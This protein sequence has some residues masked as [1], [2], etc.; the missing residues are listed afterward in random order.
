MIPVYLTGALGVETVIRT[1]NGDRSPWK[2]RSRLAFAGGVGT[3]HH[4]RIKV[5]AEASPHEIFPPCEG[6]RRIC[7]CASESSCRKLTR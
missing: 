2:S 4:G 3:P 6:D 1:V 7:V 5:A